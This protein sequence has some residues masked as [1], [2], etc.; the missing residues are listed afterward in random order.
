M[1]D[2]QS[3][4][5]PPVASPPM[6]GVSP[7]TLL[8][9]ARQ[10]QGLHIETVAASLK[11]S[12][13]KLEALE[14]DQFH[15]FPDANFVRAFAGSVCRTLK[16]DAAPVLAALPP[17]ALP[18]LAQNSE[19]INT[20]LRDERS[21]GLFT[22]LGGKPIALAVFALLLGALVLFFLPE[23]PV[24]EAEPE[25][26][27]E[28]MATP[29]EVPATTV[30]GSTPPVA[31]PAP[32]AVVA[33]APAVPAATG[34]VVPPAASPVP[35]VPP[36]STPLS[37]AP[38]QPPVSSNSS[39]VA[40]AALLSASVATP[41]TPPSATAAAEVLVLSARA[42]SWIRVRDS[43]G[44]I[45][46]K[47]TLGAGESVT[48]SDPPPLNVWVGRAD[49]TDVYIRGERFEIAGIARENVARFEVK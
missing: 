41:V 38:P 27:T 25:A 19:G 23:R 46:L 8:R 47:R 42:S 17:G 6:P 44:N 22:L 18:R 11:V 26:S 15:T 2:L 36:A 16:I 4:S 7:G 34:P 32:A 14:T 21:R 31:A 5:A 30:P 28:E 37:S 43:K 33:P 24:T 35:V 9:Q 39:P 13:A 10:A 40:A 20:R 45:L 29:T 1:S 48:V 3:S 12:V 49:M